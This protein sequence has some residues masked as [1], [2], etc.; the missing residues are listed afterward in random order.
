AFLRNRAD[1]LKIDPNRIV[2]LGRSA[3][4]QIALTVAYSVNYPWGSGVISLY[5]PTD[6]NYS[7]DNPGNPLVMNT[8]SIL[9]DYLGGSPTEA[10]ANYNQASPI[11]SVTSN[12]PPTLLLHGGRDELVSVQQSIRLS[13]R[14]AELGVPHLNLSLPW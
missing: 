3:G 9:R 13:K 12:S 1:K 5:A 6:L 8:A 10:P 4:G 11:R 14:L 2:L 7:W